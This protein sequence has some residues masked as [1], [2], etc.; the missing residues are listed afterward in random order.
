MRRRS[1]RRLPKRNVVNYAGLSGD[2]NPVHIDAE[3]AAQ[4][5]FKERIAHACSWPG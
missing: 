3:Y 5:M 1:P 2:F 4:S